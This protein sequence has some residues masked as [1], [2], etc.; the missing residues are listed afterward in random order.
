MQVRPCEHRFITRFDIGPSMIESR[1]PR[2]RLKSDPLIARPPS[3][4]TLSKAL[5]LGIA[6]YQRKMKLELDF[7][8]RGRGAADD[9][10]II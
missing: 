4:L 7:H 3:W 6:K 5:L 2:H 8:C 1:W 10:A 9:L